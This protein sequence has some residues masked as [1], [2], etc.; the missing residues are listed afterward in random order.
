MGKGAE[1]S[2]LRID[3]M[4]NECGSGFG[5]WLSNP[6]FAASVA[7][8]ALTEDAERGVGVTRVQAAS[9]QSIQPSG[10][11]NSGSTMTPARNTINN[12][13]SVQPSAMANALCNFRVPGDRSESKQQQREAGEACV[14][15]R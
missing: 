14:V 4:S 9:A 10:S 11:K 6:P 3:V 2:V 1:R 13:S 7:S 5:R 15:A 12:A 8:G